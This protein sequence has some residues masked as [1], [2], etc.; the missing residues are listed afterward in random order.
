MTDETIMAIREFLK[1][2]MFSKKCIDDINGRINYSVLDS[3]RV[4]YL[5]NNQQLYIAIVM[6]VD[7]WLSDL[8]DMEK[9]IIEYRFFQRLNTSQIADRLHYKNHSSPSRLISNILKKIKKR[10]DLIG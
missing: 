8:D 2:Y 10:G 4:V 6:K 9:E 1:L 5:K 3:E 7:C